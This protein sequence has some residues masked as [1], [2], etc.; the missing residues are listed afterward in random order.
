MP[1]KKILLQTKPKEFIATRASVV[2][3][4]ENKRAERVATG[5]PNCGITYCTSC[6]KVGYCK[7]T[8]SKDTIHLSN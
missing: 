7:R 5:G 6:D 2:K 8:C 4:G 3:Q 1:E